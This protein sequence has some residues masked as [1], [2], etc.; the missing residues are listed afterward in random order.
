MCRVFSCAVQ[1]SNVVSVCVTTLVSQTR[2]N[3]IN[4]VFSARGVI[5]SIHANTWHGVL[6]QC[7]VVLS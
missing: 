5:R 2:M 3:R 4:V 7:S 6:I 1:C